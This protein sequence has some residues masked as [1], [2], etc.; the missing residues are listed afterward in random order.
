MAKSMLTRRTLIKSLCGV[1]AACAFPGL[2]QWVKDKLAGAP[3]GY[4]DRI[5]AT[6]VG[7]PYSGRTMPVFLIR[8]DDS[9]RLSRS[10]WTTGINGD[11][12]NQYGCAKVVMRDGSTHYYMVHPGSFLYELPGP[13]FHQVADMANIGERP[14]G[15]RRARVWFA[16]ASERTGASYLV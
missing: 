7:G 15:S 4:R 16:S 10:Y 3:C 14:F 5:D 8:G 11:G 2:V 6:F 13:D 12:T 9:S 1:A